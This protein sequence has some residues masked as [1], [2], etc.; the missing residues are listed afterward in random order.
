MKTIRYGTRG[1]KLA[2][3][4]SAMVA[5]A[6][7][8]ETGATVERVVITTSGD[9]FS[10][11]GDGT[12]AQGGGTFTQ[13]PDAPNVKAMFVKEI[14]EALLDGRID[15]AVRDAFLPAPR[16]ST[17]GK[18]KQ[19]GLIAT[20]SLRRRI[21]LALARPDALF[22]PIRGN[23]DTRLG[24]LDRGE[25]DGMILAM[26]GL[27]RLGLASRRHEALPES[28]VVPAPG[29][30]TLAIEAREDRTDVLDL[31][32]V[33]ENA[34]TRLEL[35]AERAFLA[36]VGG[37]CETPLGCL[38]RVTGPQ[39]ALT[40]FW[41]EADGSKPRRLSEQGETERGREIA[42]R[43]AARMLAGAANG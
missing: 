38:A 2:L 18:L 27:R 36:A 3:A 14:E 30:G 12:P 34:Q 33:I 21:Q 20:G 22:A 6:L 23:V 19:G 31:L 26:A 7:A 4:Q 17:F 43:M 24:R 13:P 25:F 42:E 39:I 29:Q 1:S 15:F 11:Q 28:V 41:S 35:D 16:S 40:A 10:L 5:R 37:G 8:E 9:M 32:L